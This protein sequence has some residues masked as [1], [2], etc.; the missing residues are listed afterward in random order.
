MALHSIG[1]NVTSSDVRA[2]RIAAGT[3]GG[4]HIVP[5]S[6]G[7]NRNNAL[8]DN[9][10][11][12]LVYGIVGSGTAT[13]TTELTGQF[14]RQAS[15]VT[16]STA[17][18]AIQ[19]RFQGNSIGIIGAAT[20]YGDSAAYVYIDGAVAYGRIAVSTVINFS[21]GTGATLSTPAITDDTTTFVLNST[22]GF[23]SSGY[24]LIDDEV[25]QYTLS[26]STVTIVAR[27]QFNTNKSDHLYSATVYQWSNVVSFNN[28]TD[29]INGKLLFYNPFLANG[30]HTV[31]L[32]CS[33]G[34]KVYFDGYL[35]GPQIGASNIAIETG[36]VTISGLS[37][38]G[39]GHADIGSL[40]SNNSDVQVISIFGYQQT[41]PDASTD[42]ATT[43]S[44]LGVKYAT[45][46]GD[47]DSQPYLFIHNGPGSTSVTL[48]VTFV[49]IGGTIR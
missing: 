49:Y 5:K 36:S 37:T 32:V 31:T 30:P 12:R 35:I 41:S 45:A 10:D 29:F 24:L 42:T 47:F 23:S 27:A 7:G 38:S 16:T 40:V 46:L 11:P 44:K 19:L 20:P 18:A 3:V 43:M 39:N 22:T 14:S 6:V 2:D 21:V 13:F 9:L 1:G 17:N 25:I 4:E 48:R 28:T 26:G 15:L 33:G 34:G 8:V